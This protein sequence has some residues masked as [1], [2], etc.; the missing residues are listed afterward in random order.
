MLSLCRRRVARDISR[1]AFSPWARMLL[2]AA[3]CPTPLRTIRPLP[4]VQAPP[5]TPLCFGSLW[6]RSSAVRH[7]P[8]K[9]SSA[10]ITFQL[11]CL[12]LTA[13]PSSKHAPPLRTLLRSRVL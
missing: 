4:R 2:N 12:A 3:A 13:T 9:L 1:L 10:L 7:W 6:R 5:R 8:L 11:F